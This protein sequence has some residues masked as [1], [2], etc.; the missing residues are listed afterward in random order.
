MSEEQVGAGLAAKVLTVSDGVVAGTREDKSGVALAAVERDG[1]QARLRMK[2]VGQDLVD[3]SPVRLAHR[4]IDEVLLDLPG[5]EV[6][7]N[8]RMQVVETGCAYRR[9]GAPV[10]FLSFVIPIRVKQILGVRKLWLLRRLVIGCEK[11]SQ[12]LWQPK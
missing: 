12:V 8:S 4:Y 1:Q 7:L 5:A 9:R 10:D 11:Q 2:V 3:A 6:I